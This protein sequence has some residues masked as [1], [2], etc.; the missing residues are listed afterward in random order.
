MKNKIQKQI[1]IVLFATIFLPELIQAQ[2]TMT[3]EY[4]PRFEY[5]NGYKEL[6]DSSTLPAYIAAQRTRG[7]FKFKNDNLEA[8]FTLQDSRVWGEVKPKDDLASVQV[9]EAWFELPLSKVFK[10]KIGRQ[11]VKYDDERLL[12]SANWNNVGTTHDLA[13]LKYKGKDMDIHCGMAYNNAS[14]IYHGAN[15]AV[16][17]YKTL[18]YLWINKKLNKEFSL[19]FLDVADGFNKEESV[20]VIYLR[21][22]VGIFGEYKNDSLGL[23]VNG[24]GYYQSGKNKAGTEIGAFLF[25]LKADFFITKKL[26]ILAGYDYYSGNDYT[27]TAN[28][29]VNYFSNLYGSGHRFLGSMDYFTAPEHTAGAGITDIFGGIGY[30]ITDKWSSQLFYHSFAISGEIPDFTSATLTG[31]DKG[32]AS[33]IDLLFILK[34]NQ[35]VNINFGYS[36]LMGKETLSLVQLGDYKKTSH[37]GFVMINVKL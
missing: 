32:L 8:A 26:D 21:N 36:T 14:E 17:T 3:G 24:S 15:Y 16:K 27:D 12:S 11:E 10:L 1:I 31:V 4:R 37:W 22:T 19:S 25:S 30:K 9:Y 20:D 6:G 35:M 29:K 13:M 7:G 18:N 23:T 5:R 33:E 2:F 34:L 28:E